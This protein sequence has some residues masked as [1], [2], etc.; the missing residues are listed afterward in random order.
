V[1]PPEPETNPANS[2]GNDQWQPLTRAELYTKVW[3]EPMVKIA[4]EFG[5][6][7]RGLAKTCQRL[8]VP[9]PPRGYWAKLQAGKLVSKVP[10]PTA[11]PMTTSETVIHRTPPPRVASE[12]PPRDPE[13]HARIDAALL[14]FV[15]VRVAKSL[16]NPHSIIRGWMDEDRLARERSR[17]S[18]YAPIHLSITRTQTDRRRLRVL[19]AL[20]REFER[21]GYRVTAQL[22]E[23]EPV[24]IRSAT[25]ELKF[26][27]FEP[28]RRV[29]LP[30][31]EKEKQESWNKDREW[32]H[33][34]HLSGEL[35]LR[36]ESHCGGGVRSEW[37]DKSESTIEVQ[38][39]EVMAGLATAM[40]LVEDLE[41]RRRE[42]ET[43]R[44]KLEQERAERERLL[45]IE[46]A[47]WKHTL[48]L[49][50]ASRQAAGVREFL[51]KMERRT[52]S[53]PVESD[54][55]ERF[56]Q[57]IRWA[58]SKADQMD[59]LAGPVAA[60]NVICEENIGVLSRPPYRCRHAF[61]SVRDGFVGLLPVSASC[62]PGT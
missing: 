40:V 16:S 22:P 52:Q 25:A 31:T 60:H 41:R 3:S 30:L 50:T 5:I 46:A 29:R 56:V 17:E 26:V 38:I 4:K 18:I 2:F 15:P 19:S 44:W 54:L 27:L 28:M 14:S 49:A 32:K 13:L 62:L 11:K 10:L 6:S 45:Q 24:I 37:C 21:I 59:P 34:N 23:R 42:E 20:L 43:L 9:V 53:E 12:P 61:D 55:S 48:D 58:R 33:E 57:W 36:I 1:N 47:R 7:D 8:E 35:V 51:D 39:D